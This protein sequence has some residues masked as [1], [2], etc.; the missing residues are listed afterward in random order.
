MRIPCIFSRLMVCIGV[1]VL[2]RLMGRAIARLVLTNNTSYRYMIGQNMKQILTIGRYFKSR[3]R[4]MV[5]KVPISLQGFTCPN[6]DGSVAKGGCTYCKNETFS[7]SLSGLEQSSI[8]MNLNLSYNPILETQ[9]ETLKSQFY[10]YTKSHSERFGTDRYMVYFQS[11]SNTYATYDT[12]KTLYDEALRLP[13]VIGL[14]IGTRIDCIED[15]ILTLLGDYA[16]DKSDIWLE[17]GI[18]S[19]FDSTLRLINRGHGIDGAKELVQKTR[20]HGIK[21]CVHLIYGLPKESDDMM[22]ASLKEVLSWEIDGIKIHPLYI[23]KDTAMEKM[24]NAGKYEPISLENYADL[25][26]QSL[27]LMPHD[28]VVQRISAGAHDSSLIAPKW[29]FDKNIQMRYIRDRLLENGISY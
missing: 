16:K 21:V 10:H 24:Y 25:I 8:N 2:V 9:I 5:R 12:L 14:S 6:I 22:I 28:V 15:R 26:V 18:Q 4:Q 27:K 13:N 11:F 19:I 3:Y 20:S 7:P 23:V 29:C 1:S 17:Y